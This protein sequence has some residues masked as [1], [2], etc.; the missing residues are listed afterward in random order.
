MKLT[1]KKFFFI[2]LRS[3]ALQVRNI[4]MYNIYVAWRIFVWILMLFF[5]ICTF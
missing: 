2:F 1:K 4:L 3:Q 5:F